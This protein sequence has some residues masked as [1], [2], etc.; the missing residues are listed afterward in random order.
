[1]LA[2]ER[3]T[4][5]SGYLSP[6]NSLFSQAT[7]QYRNA[8]GTIDYTAPQ[9]G[10]ADPK[11][12]LGGIL[13]FGRDADSERRCIGCRKALKG[14]RGLDDGS[15]PAISRRRATDLTQSAANR[16]QRRG[17]VDRPG[18]FPHQTVITVT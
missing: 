6:E 11:A 14:F 7:T 4:P 5:Q 1:M 8:Y 15:E 13:E 10:N 2:P 12:P 3:E 16:C 9:T 17:H 18:Y